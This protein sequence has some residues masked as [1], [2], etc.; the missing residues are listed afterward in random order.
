[1][2]RSPYRATGLKKTGEQQPPLNISGNVV[3]TEGCP[4]EEAQQA[5]RNIGIRRSTTPTPMPPM[6][7]IPPSSRRYRSDSSVINNIPPQSVEDTQKARRVLHP[8]KQE[9]GAHDVEVY[10]SPESEGADHG[11]RCAAGASKIAHGQVI[12]QNREPI[13]STINE[14]G[15]RYGGEAAG[16]CDNYRF[17]VGLTKVDEASRR[18]DEHHL[19][20]GVEGDEEHVGRQWGSGWQQQKD[21]RPEGGGTGEA[22][23][24]EDGEMGDEE[25]NG[26]EWELENGTKAPEEEVR[27]EG[28]G[29]EEQEGV[30][31]ATGESHGE[32]NNIDDDD[33]AKQLLL[34]RRDCAILAG[35]AKI[36]LALAASEHRRIYSRFY[37]W[38]RVHRYADDERGGTS[39]RIEQV[40]PKERDVC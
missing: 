30:E 15:G 17:E 19:V 13:V 34:Y 7:P 4:A 26:D 23:K 28:E 3:N 32:G 33:E 6:P 20:I 10:Q 1:M 8:T 25:I 18:D 12:H 2:P 24:E 16:A 37:Q 9:E 39:L 22:E 21:W 29:N 36:V 27:R 38:K 31:T 11:K 14:K 35:T 40:G 5:A